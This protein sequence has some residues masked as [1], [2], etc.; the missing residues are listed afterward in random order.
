MISYW[1]VQDFSDPDRTGLQLRLVRHG[2]PC[3]DRKVIGGFK[4]AVLSAPVKRQKARTERDFL[5]HPGLHHDFATA[6][7]DFHE[8]RIL[9]AELPRICAMDLQNGLWRASAQ[10]FVLPGAGHR[11][12]MMRHASSR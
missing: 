5:G 8:I 4:K 11:M 3:R 6:R 1:K 7:D 12:P 2:I 9:D 10:S